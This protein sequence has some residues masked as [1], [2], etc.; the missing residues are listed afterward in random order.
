[1][2]STAAITNIKFLILFLIK[3]HNKEMYLTVSDIPFESKIVIIIII[4]IN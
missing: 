3:M 4:T 1:M 2:F